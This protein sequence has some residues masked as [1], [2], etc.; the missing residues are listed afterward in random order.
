MTN[1]IR[2]FLLSIFL[3]ISLLPAQFANAHSKVGSCSK[4][5]AYKTKDRI[6]YIC[7]KKNNVKSWVKAPIK[8]VSK[9]K[10]TSLEKEVTPVNTPLQTDKSIDYKTKRDLYNKFKKLSNSSSIVYEQWRDG[11]D[12]INKEDN[13]N[14]FI[15]PKFTEVG[16]NTIKSRL[17]NAVNQL[18]KYAPLDRIKVFVEVGF[19][20]DIPGICDRVSSRSTDINAMKCNS[21]ILEAVSKQPFISAGT[22]ESEGNFAPII[23]LSYSSNAS[24]SIVL[25][26]S[27]EESLY[28][29]LSYAILEHEYF[30]IIQKDEAGV[31]QAEQFPC[32]LQEGSASYFSLLNSTIYNPDAFTQFRS[33]YF[34]WT[35][36]SSDNKRVT[37]TLEYIRLW[38]ESLSIKYKGIDAHNEIC[39]SLA[40]GDKIYSQGAILTEW[41][42]G[43]I[44]F[45]NFF[46][47]MREIEILGFEQAFEKHF[48]QSLEKSYDEM[49]EYLYKE[50]KLIL[51][52]YNWLNKYDCYYFLDEVNGFC[53]TNFRS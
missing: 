37:P 42:I 48:T 7:V 28:N 31:K 33:K 16:V 30:H 20:E 21:Q 11:F 6:K 8:S 5:G 36:Y 29:W 13:L 39:S 15:S 50:N 25:V 22:I 41:I 12:S 46:L 53:T 49:A 4:I 18:N 44:G 3:T 32:W 2:C 45:N 24:V 40:D 26:V 23:D 51:D 10:V 1:I 47:M 35:N 34:S 9:T 38:V 19:A 52:N 14:Y 27:T 43:K 17:N